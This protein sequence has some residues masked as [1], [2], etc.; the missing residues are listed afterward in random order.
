MTDTDWPTLAF[1]EVFH[2]GSMRPEMKGRTHN[3][4]S[5]EGNGLS[6]SRDPQAWTEIAKLGGEPTWSLKPAPGNQRC[7]D[8]LDAHALTPQEWAVVTD[9]AQ[10]VQLLQPAR[11]VEISWL[12]EEAD[13]R[14]S[15]VFDLDDPR[16]AQAAQQEHESLIEGAEDES[17]VQRIEFAGWRATPA[18]NARMGFA[19]PLGLQ[20][21]LA[22]TAYVEDVLFDAHGIHGVWWLDEVDVQALSAP[23]GV[24]HR[25]ALSHWQA[26]VVQGQ[27]DGD[28]PP[29][30]R[31]P[32][33]RG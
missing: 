3:A 26:T 6:V 31:P 11:L 17:D 33:E 30:V 24:I 20:N 27:D 13:A 22:L 5:Q 12:D 10:S 14:R 19:V 9:W 4:T 8:F 2:V 1:D 16:D 23:R 25:K 21:D 18:L 15:M 28:Q 32:R 29:G 7:A